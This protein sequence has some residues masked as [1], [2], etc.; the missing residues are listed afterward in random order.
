MDDAMKPDTTVRVLFGVALLLVLLD[1][2]S[3]LLLATLGTPFLGMV[4]ASMALTAVF[5]MAGIAFGFVR[6]GR[7]EA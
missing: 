3:A 4:K 1:G 2:T 6:R 7:S 5:A